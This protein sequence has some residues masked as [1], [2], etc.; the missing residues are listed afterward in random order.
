MKVDSLQDRNRCYSTD[1][2][3][4]KKTRD[5]LSCALQVTQTQLEHWEREYIQLNEEV[6]IPIPVVQI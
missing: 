4:L 5:T 2:S 6:R 1:V 3:I